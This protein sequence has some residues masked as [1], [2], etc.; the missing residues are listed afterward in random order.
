MSAESVWAGF[1]SFLVFVMLAGATV[2]ALDSR[3]GR[4]ADAICAPQQGVS[5]DGDTWCRT[6]DD[7]LER[8]EVAP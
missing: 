1:V 5:I 4:K 7:T 8:A 3:N 6:R 2:L